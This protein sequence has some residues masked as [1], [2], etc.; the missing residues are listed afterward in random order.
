MR[1]ISIC[2][3]FFTSSLFAQANMEEKVRHNL[4][5]IVDNAF[6]DLT[7]YDDFLTLTDSTGIITDKFPFKYYM[8]DIELSTNDY[9]K[10]FNLENGTQVEIQFKFRRF[11]PDYFEQVYYFKI[12]KNWISKAYMVLNIY[13]KTKK[14]TK[15]Y[16]FKNNKYIIEFMSPEVR[17]KAAKLK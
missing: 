2:F 16:A 15:K 13:N 12:D 10:L 8:A 1:L 5:L 9:L 7:I 6:L 4:I 17:T 14:N 3:I 11:S